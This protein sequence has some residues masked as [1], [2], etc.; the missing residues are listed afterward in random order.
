MPLAI[1]L[2]FLAAT[3][4]ATP[5]EIGVEQPLPSLMLMKAADDVAVIRFGSGPPESVRVKDIVGSTRAVVAEIGGGRIVIDETFTGADGQPN[6]ARIV[7]KEGERGG[8][9]YLQRPDE[10]PFAGTVMVPI[11]PPAPE[12]PKSA[13]KKPPQM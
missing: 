5:R 1:A 12:T 7:I 4:A 10:R 9:R 8:T 11:T 2:I 3:Q 6:R 13:P